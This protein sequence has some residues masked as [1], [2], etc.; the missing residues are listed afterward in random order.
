MA[1]KN[2]KDLI[3][4]AKQRDSCWVA[5][6]I[7]DFTE[8]LFRLMEER[9]VN[10]VELARRVAASP[11]YITRVLRG[12]TNLTLETM[13]RLTQAVEGKLCVHIE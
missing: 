10:K 11:A 6:A 2:F 13:V 3:S 12:N 1:N 7:Q 8:D 9:G 5:K 4:K